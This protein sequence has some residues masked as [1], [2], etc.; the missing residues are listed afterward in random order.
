VERLLG[1]AV[2]GIDGTVAGR[3]EEF[4][5]TREGD[6]WVITEFDIGRAALLERLAV[7]HVPWLLP[8]HR[9]AGYRVRWDQLDL[10][11]PDHPRLTVP[12]EEIRTIRRR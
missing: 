6:A 7:R 8:G 2:R 5:A 9:P 10:S 12:L 4:R 11:D 3:L 1:R